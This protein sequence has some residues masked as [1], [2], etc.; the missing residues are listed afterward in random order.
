MQR[1][2]I[3]LVDLVLMGFLVSSLF[4]LPVKN[5][6]TPFNINEIEPSSLSFP[7]GI[8]WPLKTDDIDKARNIG[9]DTVI[10]GYDTNISLEETPTYSAI[11]LLNHCQ[12]IGM[13]VVFELSYFLR[14]NDRGI[15][16][17]KCQLRPGAAIL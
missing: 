11:T 8:Y 10:F 12:N 7:L 4:A 5:V 9:L 6:A 3:I 14:W 16:P 17:D 1:N 15:S 2:R 13:N